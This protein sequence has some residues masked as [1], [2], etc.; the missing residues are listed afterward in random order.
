M[1]LIVLAPLLGATLFA[2][3]QV[4]QLSGKASEL[5]RIADLIAIATDVARFDIL[6]GIEYNSS[7]AQYIDAN[8][9]P[10]YQAIIAESEQLVAQI[11]ANL[12]RAKASVRN[13]AFTTHIEEALKLYEQVPAVRTYYLARRPGDDREARTVNNSV[14][15]ALTTPLA[16]TIRALVNESAELPIRLRIQTLIWCADLNSNATTETGMYCW[17]H[18][19]GSFKSLENCAN[20]ELATDMRRRV[21]RHLLA[22]TVP[23]LRPY[24]EKIFSDPI[25]LEA[26]RMVRTFAQEN[27]GQKHVFNAAHLPVWRELTEVKR[28]GL[29]VAMQ[30]YV[31]SELQ[32]FAHD[33][34]DRVHRERRWMIGL[35]AGVLIVSGIVVWLLGR[36]VFNAVTRAVLSL[37]QSIHNMLQVTTQST[38]AAKQL[39]DVVSQQAAALEETAASLEELTTTNRQNSDNARAIAGRMKETDTLV[40]RATESMRHLVAAVQQIATTSGQTKHIASTID[41]ISFQTNLLALNASIEAA[42]AGEAGAGFAVVAEEVRQ[43]AMRAAAESASIAKLIE[44]A[45]QLTG[46]GVVLSEKVNAI[47]QQV[48]TQARTATGCMT[49]IQSST[50]ELV[51]GI[52]EINAATRNLDAQ[53]Q[54]TAAIAQENATSA[55]FIDNQTAALA[56]SIALLETLIALDPAAPASASTAEATPVPASHSPSVFDSAPESDLVPAARE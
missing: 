38:D 27:S 22:N 51:R 24:F 31:L 15:T 2:I 12:P 19:L 11:R 33:Y 29:L 4:R 49:G 25:Y 50:E 28:Y 45:H 32:S 44:G 36:A 5:S 7:W 14:Y 47:F 53:T 55:E 56:S 41:E 30:P 23:E 3:Y 35:L 40:Q 37:K 1:L 16:N 48:E 46:E 26:D 34:I 13:Q 42:R 54:Q 18:E 9:S 6:M 43:M 8:N 10:K 20:A 52:E 17:G 39:A 21:E